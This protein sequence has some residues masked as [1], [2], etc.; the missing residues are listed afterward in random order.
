MR[1]LIIL[2]FPFQVLA[3]NWMSA[4]DFADQKVGT[5]DPQHYFKQNICEIKESAPCFEF[6]EDTR[7]VKLIG[8]VVVP[9]PTGAAQAS[10]DDAAK[11][12]EITDRLAK[13]ITRFGNL[14]TCLITLAAPSPSIAQLKSCL[15]DQI[16]EELKERIPVADL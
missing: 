9:D 15:I 10:L 11:A 1:I 2:L 5:G 12:Q 4:S 7:I 3:A 16:K 8:G 14:E 6:G 13:G